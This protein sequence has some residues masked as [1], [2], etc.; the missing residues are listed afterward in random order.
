MLEL[1]NTEEL[2]NISGGHDG[3]AYE[4]GKAIGDGI[5][6]GAIIFGVVVAFFAPKS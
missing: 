5:K 6:R 1:L 4:I 3:T 2:R